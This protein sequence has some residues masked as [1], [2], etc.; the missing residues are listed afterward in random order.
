MV[1]EAP[2]LLPRQATAILLDGTRQ[3]RRARA[4]FPVS[5]YAIFIQP[6]KLSLT[7]SRFLG[8]EIV[9]ILE[10]LRQCGIV[11]RDL[12]PENLLLDGTNHL[13]VID[14]GTGKF[15]QL[16]NNVDFIKKINAIK[17]K[18]AEAP[19]PDEEGQQER[20]NSFV[21]TPFY[22]SPELIKEEEV[23][24]PADIWAFGILM[25]RMVTGKF[26]YPDMSDYELFESIKNDKIT[27]P[28]DID[29]DARDLISKLLQKDPAQRIGAGTEER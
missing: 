21:G 27:F 22:L 4:I 13:K 19:K 18:F 15:I 12:K 8:A 16:A 25:Y 26:P 2:Q 14:F 17:A 28:D 7:E 1:G 5:K 10:F 11:H 6:A 23:S 9:L 3:K 20:R 24:F 29:A